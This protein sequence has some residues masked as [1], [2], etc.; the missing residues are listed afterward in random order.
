MRIF[1]LLQ[2]FFPFLYGLLLIEFVNFDASVLNYK[3]IKR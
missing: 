2:A 1:W 3:E